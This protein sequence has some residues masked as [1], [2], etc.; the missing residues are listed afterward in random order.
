MCRHHVVPYHTVLL[1]GPGGVGR[2]F[3]HGQT[4]HCNVS[5]STRKTPFSTLLLDLPPDAVPPHAV[6][7]HAGVLV[8]W[9][10]QQHQEA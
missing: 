7:L 9:A 1:Q 8:V 5:D 3:C 4:A 2:A 10:W 6:L